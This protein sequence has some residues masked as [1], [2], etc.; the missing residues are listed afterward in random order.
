MGSLALFLFYSRVAWEVNALQNLLL[1][2][3]LMALPAS[4]GTR[5]MP[6]IA[7]L[8]LLLA[9]SLGLE[10][11]HIRCSGAVLRR[12]TLLVALKWPRRRARLLADRARPPGSTRPVRETLCRRWPL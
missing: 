1:A 5:P 9:F 3:V 6:L 2:L 8:L 7:A 11:R 12:T 10:S 4:A